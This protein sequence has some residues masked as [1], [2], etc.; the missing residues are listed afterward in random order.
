MLGHGAG[1]GYTGPGWAR[2]TIPVCWRGRYVLVNCRNIFRHF[3]SA[4]F[5]QYVVT[6]TQT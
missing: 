2:L 1:I 3:W 6:V 4:S 5:G